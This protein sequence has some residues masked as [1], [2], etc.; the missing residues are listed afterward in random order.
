MKNIYQEALQSLEQ[1]RPVSIETL[2]S[3]QAGELASGLSR[4]LTELV[5]VEDAR[6]RRF[7][8]VTAEEAEGPGRGAHR[9]AC[10]RIRGQVRLLRDGGGRPARLCQRRPLPP[11]QGSAL[12]QL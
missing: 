5:P 8:R 4:R 2:L 9:P 1:N 12:R 7:A 10:V 3:G 6:G 11:G